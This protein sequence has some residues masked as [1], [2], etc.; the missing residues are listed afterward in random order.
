MVS[1][2]LSLRFILKDEESTHAITPDKMDRT[3][4]IPLVIGGEGR[5]YQMPY[6]LTEE[7]ATPT[8]PDSEKTN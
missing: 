5:K 7:E 4:R 3:C 2:K 6:P 1:R 8:V